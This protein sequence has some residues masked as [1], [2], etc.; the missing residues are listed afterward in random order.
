MLSSTI[1]TIRVH[2]PAHEGFVSVDPQFNLDDPLGREWQKGQENGM[3]V[4]QPG[5]ST[6]WRV[7]L[8]LF[9]LTVG[10][11]RYTREAGGDG[12]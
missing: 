11:S 6:Q 4:L 12:V 9:P 7:R 8:E 1:H 2:A 3:V 5:Q 10:P